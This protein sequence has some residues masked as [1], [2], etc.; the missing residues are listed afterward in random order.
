MN[1]EFVGETKLEYELKVISI[2]SLVVGLNH[3]L[4]AWECDITPN[5]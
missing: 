5:L 4:G 1:Q 3:G 2:S